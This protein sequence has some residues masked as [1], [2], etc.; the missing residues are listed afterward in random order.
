MELRVITRVKG[1]TDTTVIMYLPLLDK[2]K[3]DSQEQTTRI[4][5]KQNKER[6][7]LQ[8][9]VHVSLKKYN[10]F[11]YFWLLYVVLIIVLIYVHVLLFWTIKRP[12][13]TVYL[14]HNTLY[15]KIFEWNVKKFFFFFGSK[16]FRDIS[17]YHLKNRY[18][19]VRK[20]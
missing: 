5:I 11:P 10:W 19:T 8:L 6:G 2:K 20:I 13:L 15:V 7:H 12:N 4:Q 1:Q 9:H 18:V 3:T 16:N 14:S 17:L